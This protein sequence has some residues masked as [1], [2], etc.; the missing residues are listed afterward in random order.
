M[1]LFYQVK[2]SMGIKP[3]GRLMPLLG[4]YILRLPPSVFCHL[5]FSEKTKG[6]RSHKKSFPLLKLV[7]FPNDPFLVP[8]IK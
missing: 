2:S 3:V 1:G 8:K 6:N 5:R 7:P 4:F